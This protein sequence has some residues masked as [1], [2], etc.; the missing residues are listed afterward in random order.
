MESID[1]FLW[2]YLSHSA[3]VQLG[4]KSAIHSSLLFLKVP[5]VACQVTLARTHQVVLGVV[6]NAWFLKRKCRGQPRID[7][8]FINLTKKNHMHVCL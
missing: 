2:P 5:S 4:L 6:V 3:E 8:R 7:T 1:T